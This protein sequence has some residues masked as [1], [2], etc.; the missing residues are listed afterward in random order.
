MDLARHAR[1]VLAPTDD[2]V[3]LDSMIETILSGNTHQKDGVRR[4]LYTPAKG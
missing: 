4:L 3:L 2:P 1:T